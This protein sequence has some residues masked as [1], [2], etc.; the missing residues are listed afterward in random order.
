MTPQFLMDM[1]KIQ[2]VMCYE[3]E[4]DTGHDHHEDFIC[5]ACKRASGH[6][7]KRAS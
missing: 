1:N 7:E 4:D 5:D 2:C 6:F 3:V